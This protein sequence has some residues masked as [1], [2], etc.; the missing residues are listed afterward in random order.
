MT[1]HM[2]GGH[3]VGHPLIYADGFRAGN[4][5]KVQQELGF[6]T[7]ASRHFDTPEYQKGGKMMLARMGRWGTTRLA[8][9]FLTGSSR[10][11]V[12]KKMR[13]GLNF[14]IHAF[15]EQF[16]SPESGIALGAGTDRH[17]LRTQ[18]LALV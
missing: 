2:L 17:G 14:S 12:D 10:S 5:H 13:S 15:V 18:K 7:L 4:P 11:E 6:I 9:E 8:Q 3:L 1:W 16:E